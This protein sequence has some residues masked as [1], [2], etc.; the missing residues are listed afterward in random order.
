MIESREDFRP[1]ITPWCYC[2]APEDDS[3][4]FFKSIALAVAPRV[5]LHLES[6]CLF[7]SGAVMSSHAQNFFV[8]R[9][10]R[11]PLL[12]EAAPLSPKKHI[13]PRPSV[14]GG[15]KHCISTCPRAAGEWTW[16]ATPEPVLT[17]SEQTTDNRHR[18]NSQYPMTSG[19]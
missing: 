18:L 4:T 15:S 10:P 12:L 19:D 14:P 9:F 16:R 5:E 3:H 6:A 13:L 17:H 11:H 7:K 8:L 1:V 2:L